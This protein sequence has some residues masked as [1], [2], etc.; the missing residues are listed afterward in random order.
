MLYTTVLFVCGTE[1]VTHCTTRAWKMGKVRVLLWNPDPSP[2]RQWASFLVCSVLTL[3]SPVRRQL[4]GNA[5]D[6]SVCELHAL[7]HVLRELEPHKKNICS[8]KMSRLL[9]HGH[10]TQL[11][12]D[13]IRWTL[14]LTRR[15]W[16]HF[17]QMLPKLTVKQNNIQSSHSNFQVSVLTACSHSFPGMMARPH[18]GAGADP[19]SEWRFWLLRQHHLW[20]LICQTI[21]RHLQK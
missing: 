11:K 7:L 10:A 21:N 9:L 15:K 16:G 2:D 12:T 5:L 19:S 17:N 18:W 1:C 8:E 4:T 13:N 14:V 6:G 20:F 3:L